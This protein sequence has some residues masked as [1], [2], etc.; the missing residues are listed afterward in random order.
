M[1]VIILEHIVLCDIAATQLFHIFHHLSFMFF[2]L[3]IH[4]PLICFQA[5][6]LFVHYILFERDAISFNPYDTISNFLFCALKFESLLNPL[7]NQINLAK[8]QL[9]YKIFL[10]KNIN[11][12]SIIVRI[13]PLSHRNSSFSVNIHGSFECEIFNF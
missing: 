8:L 2:F 1:F 7:Y 10:F 11:N 3:V 13:L 9:L 5:F 4:L 6:N 12:S